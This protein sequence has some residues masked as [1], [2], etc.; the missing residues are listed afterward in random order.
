M[1]A[2]EMPKR[3][4]EGWKML[5]IGNASGGLTADNDAVLRAGRAT[6]K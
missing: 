6:T 3:I 1:S 2:G 4:Q 5:G